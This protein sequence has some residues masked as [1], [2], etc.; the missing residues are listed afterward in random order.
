MENFDS[1]L[2]KKEQTII[3]EAD[4]FEKYPQFLKAIG[5]ETSM[6]VFENEKIKVAFDSK[7]ISLNDFYSEEFAELR[8]FLLKSRIN[9]EE[10][11]QLTSF[12]IK[13]ENAEMNLK[14]I[15]SKAVVLFKK[16]PDLQTGGSAYQDFNNLVLL[17]KKPSS[18]DGILTMMHELGHIEDK[19]LLD[20]I[21]RVKDLRYENIMIGGYDEDVE[22]EK[23]ALQLEWERDAWA[24]ALNKTRPY[25]EGFELPEGALEEYIHEYA[26]GSYCKIMPE[27]Y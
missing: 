21:Q 15:L 12:K 2:L 1:Y 18:P 6:D 4:L 16:H 8:Y 27:E 3:D 22:K 5:K 20:S 24:Y 14:D 11:E 26:L 10:Y 9:L 7:N 19:K 23:N 13:S 17:E 25:I